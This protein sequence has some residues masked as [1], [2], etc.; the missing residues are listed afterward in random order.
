MD[1][2]DK[3]NT[4]NS[5]ITTE[6]KESK[7]ANS[8]NKNEIPIASFVLPM[9]HPILVRTISQPCDISQNYVL[10]DL[11]TYTIAPSMYC[12]K[13]QRTV[14]IITADLPNYCWLSGI[15]VN[16]PIQQD[17][18][19]SSDALYAHI[20]LTSDNDICFGSQDANEWVQ[21]I[22]SWKKFPWSIPYKMAMKMNL[23]VQISIS[24]PANVPLLM[25]VTISYKMNKHISQ[26]DNF[27][28]VTTDGTPVHIWDCCREIDGSKILGR[29]FLC[30]EDEL[31][32]R[33]IHPCDYVEPKEL[34]SVVRDW[35]TVI[36][37]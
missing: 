34:F 10:P 26:D 4:I 13:G 11:S 9:Y 29:Q 37:L 31:L 7:D 22:N 23:K 16:V 28:F 20:I 27:V 2:N 32:C 21:P 14:S 12:S 35:E 30:K 8:E 3:M 1:T 17:G 25:G 15:C 5:I 24:Y 33:V 6:N 19:A 36:P 18:V